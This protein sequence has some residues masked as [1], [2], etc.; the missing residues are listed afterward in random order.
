LIDLAT[1]I[2]SPTRSSLTFRHSFSPSAKLGAGGL[3]LRAFAPSSGL[4]APSGDE[5]AIAAS[6][7]GI[8]DDPSLDTT[9]DT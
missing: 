8:D 5:A 4:L 7:C 9:R 6:A 1:A 3:E 2:S